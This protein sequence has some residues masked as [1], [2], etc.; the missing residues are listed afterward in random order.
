MEINQFGSWNKSTERIV[1]TKTMRSLSFFSNSK[2]LKF[3]ERVAAI[4]HLDELNI[5]KRNGF[6]DEVTI[7]CE[8]KRIFTVT[9]ESKQF[10]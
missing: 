6:N 3:S 2:L 10:L 1:L 9:C 5:F 4:F 7:F 8:R